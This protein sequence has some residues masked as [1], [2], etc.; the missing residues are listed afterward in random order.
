[1]P[2]RAARMPWYTLKARLSGGPTVLRGRAIPISNI[3][4]KGGC[5]RRDYSSSVALRAACPLLQ[6]GA[7]CGSKALRGTYLLCT[8]TK[9][10]R[11][12][13]VETIKREGNASGEARQPPEGASPRT[14]SDSGTLGS[15]LLSR[16]LH[17]A[18]LKC[19]CSNQGA[20]IYISRGGARR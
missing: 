19:D 15:H 4:L 6:L 20:S 8:L 9:G 16:R 13:A 3:L 14:L 7:S 17:P 1:M 12:E 2:P 18:S 11:K 5:R 10:K